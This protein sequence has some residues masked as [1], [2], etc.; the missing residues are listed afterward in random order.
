M[1]SVREEVE[2]RLE[3]CRQW[4]MHLCL[5]SLIDANQLW[6]KSDECP[7]CVGE[8]VEFDPN[9]FPPPF[10]WL[11]KDTGYVV[12][13]L[14]S[15]EEKS[16]LIQDAYDEERRKFE[17][18]T[19]KF[20]VAN[21]PSTTTD[22]PR[23]PEEVRIAVWRRDNGCCARCGSRERLEYDHIIPLSKGG[24]NTIRNIELLCEQCNRSKGDR[25]Q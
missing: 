8:F 15:D 1:K 12:S 14:F 23:I 9:S 17:R 22:R 19:H 11:F 20:A 24:S 18:L 10:E 21:Q 2:R 13:G 6:Q 16:L 5:K 3:D 4:N 25:I 7:V